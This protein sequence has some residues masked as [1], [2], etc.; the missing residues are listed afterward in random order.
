MFD[1][2]PESGGFKFC[3]GFVVNRHDHTLAVLRKPYWYKLDV[4]TDFAR[5]Q[6]NLA[7]TMVISTPHGLKMP[8]WPLT[9]PA[10]SREIVNDLI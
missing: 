3:S 4:V 2:A 1:Q 10:G 5:S 8:P 6:R 7:P 9:V